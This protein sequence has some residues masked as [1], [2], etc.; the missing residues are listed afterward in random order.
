VSSHAHRVALAVEAAIA[1]ILVVTGCG[2]GGSTPVG[3]PKPPASSGSSAAP[4]APT[5]GSGAKKIDACTLLSDREAVSILGEPIAM[6]GPA[7]GA[8]ESVCEWDSASEFSVTVSVGTPGTAPGNTFKPDPVEGT[9][10]PVPGLSGTGFYFDG[11]RV[12]F[13]ADDRLNEVQVVTDPTGDADKAKSEQLA[14][15]TSTRIEGAK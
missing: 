3:A 11:G 7:S 4:S 14:A 6:K 12:D 8:G 5:S 15:L 9:P 2:R 10:E 1:A 13:A